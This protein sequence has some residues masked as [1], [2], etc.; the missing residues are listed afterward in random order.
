MAS[1][2]FAAGFV[3]LLDANDEVCGTPQFVMIDNRK[4][5]AIIEEVSVEEI[6]V[7]GGNADAGGFR[8]QVPTSG[9]SE[10]PAKG[11]PV[12]KLGEGPTFEILGDV[13][14]LNEAVY[15]IVAGDPSAE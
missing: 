9:F 2:Q 1:N 13:R 14:K 8:C 11:D 5:R 4:H 6:L 12:Q 7:A 10:D 15:G 3:E